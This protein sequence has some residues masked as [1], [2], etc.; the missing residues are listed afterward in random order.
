MTPEELSFLYGHAL[1]YA[2][3][4]VDAERAHAYANWYLAQYA[5]DREDVTMED[6]PAHTYAYPKFQDQYASDQGE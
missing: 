5:F 6:M 4:Y 3:P 2:N 1:D